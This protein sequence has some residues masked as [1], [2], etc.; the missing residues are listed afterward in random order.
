MSDEVTEP[1]PAV[2][3][4]QGD[5][6]RQK[7]AA[8]RVAVENRRKG[9]IR[10]NSIPATVRNVAVAGLLVLLLVGGSYAIFQLF[11]VESGPIAIGLFIVVGV[12]IWNAW[13]LRIILL[14]ARA[15]EAPDYLQFVEKSEAEIANL[16]RELV[17]LRKKGTRK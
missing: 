13:S 15:L 12:L 11:V 10:Q 5:I 17:E 1:D 6:L 8:I 7:I 2:E 4:P 9:I 14:N 16:Q 3:D